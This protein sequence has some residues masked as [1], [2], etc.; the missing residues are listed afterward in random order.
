MILRFLLLSVEIGNQISFQSCRV[1]PLVQFGAGWG[2]G[3]DGKSVIQL[4]QWSAMVDK[5]NDIT[6]CLLCLYIS[7]QFLSK[8]YPSYYMWCTS[9]FIFRAMDFLLELFRNLLE[10]QDWTM[11]QACS[12][13]YA[14]TLKQWHGW[15][16]SSSFSVMF[17][18][19]N[20]M[21][22]SHSSYW[23]LNYKAY[24]LQVAC[25]FLFKFW[26]V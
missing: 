1:Q 10:H 18:P 12:D 6:V 17:C 11:S 21:M 24:I 9:Y 15:F 13:S 5:V 26:T 25:F 3:Q 14:K 8:C 2:W 23:P 22:R 16:A 7:I 20:H 19:F 4:H